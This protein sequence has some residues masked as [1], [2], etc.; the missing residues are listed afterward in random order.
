[1][2]MS[3]G[4]HETTETRYPFKNI[5]DA[6]EMSTGR[7]GKGNK[8]SALKN[9]S[10]RLNSKNWKRVWLDLNG[11]WSNDATRFYNKKKKKNCPFRIFMKL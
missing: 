4:Q 5:K 1:M 10:T 2:L 8:S 6:N 3:N 9:E 11:G 7:E